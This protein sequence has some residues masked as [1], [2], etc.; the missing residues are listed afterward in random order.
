V[1]TDEELAVSIQQGNQSALTELVNRHHSRLI[2]YLYRLTGGNRGL[3]E[4]MAQETFLRVIRAI[5]QYRYPRTFKTWLYAIATNIARDHFKRA[6]MRYSM[7][8]VDSNEYINL[9]TDHQPETT[10]IVDAETQGVINALMSLSEHQRVVVVLRYY[11]G[12]ALQDIAT[13][14]DIPVGTVKS[15]LSL[16]LK[17]LK[18]KL[19]RSGVYEK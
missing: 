7:I 14:L 19:E 16:G 13:T 12:L 10:L 5:E 17:K 11:E 18:E 4:D 2:G 3:A 1:Q 9:S 15:R 6:E 8:D